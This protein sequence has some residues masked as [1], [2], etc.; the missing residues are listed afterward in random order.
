M[1]KN[2]LFCCLNNSQL[3]PELI[4]NQT[5]DDIDIQLDH[6]FD[7]NVE[8]DDYVTLLTPPCEVVCDQATHSLYLSFAYNGD[9]SIIP[10]DDVVHEHADN[11]VIT[12]LNSHI[13]PADITAYNFIREP[14]DIELAQLNNTIVVGDVVQASSFNAIV[15][16]SVDGDAH[17]TINWL[18]YDPS[19]SINA[20]PG[21]DQHVEAGSYSISEASPSQ[22]DDIKLVLHQ[23]AVEWLPERPGTTQQNYNLTDEHPFVLNQR[24]NPH[25]YAAAQRTHNYAFLNNYLAASRLYDL[26]GGP[27]SPHLLSNHLV[28]VMREVITLKDKDRADM[29]RKRGLFDTTPKQHTGRNFQYRESGTYCRH[30]MANCTCGD[31]FTAILMNDIYQEDVMNQL[32]QFCEMHPVYLIMQVF[33]NHVLG[34][35]LIVAGTKQGDW[36]RHQTGIVFSPNTE[37][38]DLERHYVHDDILPALCLVNHHQAYGF[39]FEVL[40]RQSMGSCY[41][42]VAVAIPRSQHRHHVRTL[43]MNT[44]ITLSTNPDQHAIN[45]ARFDAPLPD[46][47]TQPYDVNIYN[48]SLLK[49]SANH[50]VDDLDQPLML[51]HAHSHMCEHCHR[52]YVHIHKSKEDNVMLANHRQFKYDCPYVACTNYNHVDCNCT[53]QQHKDATSELLKRVKIS[54]RMNPRALIDHTLQVQQIIKDYP[55]KIAEIPPGDL[56]EVADHKPRPDLIGNVLTIHNSLM[57]PNGVAIPDDGLLYRYV[58]PDT[59]KPEFYRVMNGSRFNRGIYVSQNMTGCLVI[60]FDP[61]EYTIKTDTLNRLHRKCSGVDSRKLYDLV[62]NAVYAEVPTATPTLVLQVADF[63]LRNLTAVFAHKNMFVVSAGAHYYQQAVSEALHYDY[64]ILYNIRRLGL[65]RAL[66]IEWVKLDCLGCTNGVVDLAELHTYN[67]PK[68]FAGAL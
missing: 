60:L 6:T 29:C 1:I 50:D 68:L 65:W 39:D 26:F 40:T 34:G 21:N 18:D 33:P 55:E 52:L 5:I 12:F 22:S 46:H 2:F 38:G 25:K 11:T 62:H 10:H 64:G 14:T 7:G 15:A 23:Q 43:M 63:T 17:E 51:P 41:N 59:N 30:T 57:T 16:R 24:D 48:A 42:V 27:R 53:T 20:Q 47:A 61:E 35:D 58:N 19:H 37:N 3:N 4:I 44:G 67:R 56:P 8:C 54:Y 13:L 49:R 45:Q 32:Y 31:G 28:H 66:R 9:L 36:Y